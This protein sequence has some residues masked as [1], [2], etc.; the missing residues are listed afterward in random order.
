M[1][2]CPYCGA[3]TEDAA[4]FC[5]R[6]GE[7][8]VGDEDEREG[9]L[10]RQ[11]IQYLQGV[12]HGA[13][14]LDPASAYHEGLAAD[15]SA[16]VEDVS[17]LASIDSLDPASLLDVRDR[18]LVEFA[19]GRSPDTDLKDI[20]RQALGVAVLVGLLEDGFD[21]RTLD[22]LRAQRLDGDE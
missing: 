8:L 6:C 11:S 7:R 14:P 3:T 9:F 15:V 5:D 10:R 12:R 19:A 16:A 21:S 13:R 4:R 17:Y 22:E 2:E 1:V 20:E 18:D